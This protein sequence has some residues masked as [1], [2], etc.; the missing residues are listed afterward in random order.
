MPKHCTE[1]PGALV[2]LGHCRQ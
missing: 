2:R 1:I